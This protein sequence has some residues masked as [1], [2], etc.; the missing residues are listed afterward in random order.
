[1]V[2]TGKKNQIE[3]VNLCRISAQ[4]NDHLTSGQDHTAQ[5]ILILYQ[6]A[7]FKF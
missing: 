5:P 1:M 7:S 3:A 4:K 2:L 6:E